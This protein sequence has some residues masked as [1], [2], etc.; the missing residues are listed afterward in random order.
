MKTGVTFQKFAELE[1][2]LP[3]IWREF[4]KNISHDVSSTLT[5]WDKNLI[6]NR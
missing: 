3:W 1:K 2:F 5:K 4:Y 6:E